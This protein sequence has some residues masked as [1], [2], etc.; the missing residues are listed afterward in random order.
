[1][2]Y[3]NKGSGDAMKKTKE[4][5]VKKEETK[6]NFDLSTLTLEELIEVNEDINVF[7]DYLEETKIETEEKGKEEDE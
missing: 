5:K 4:T 3:N 2:K 6:E 1:M 7:I